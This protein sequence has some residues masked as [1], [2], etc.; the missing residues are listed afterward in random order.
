[1]PRKGKMARRFQELLLF[2][3]S[4]LKPFPPSTAMLLLLHLKLYERCIKCELK[5]AVF[6]FIVMYCELR[7]FRNGNKYLQL[8]KGLPL[9]GDSLLLCMEMYNRDRKSVV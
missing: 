5:S 3:S 6:V 9:M 4:G 8:P 7:S 1:M 2:F